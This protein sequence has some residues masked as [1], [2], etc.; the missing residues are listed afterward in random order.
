MAFDQLTLQDGPDAPSLAD[1][2]AAMCSEMELCLPGL[3]QR[4]FA[5]MHYRF[6]I[7]LFD[8]N[9]TLASEGRLQDGES[10]EVTVV[11]NDELR[12]LASQ[13]KHPD[14]LF[15]LYPSDETGRELQG[16]H[17]D[18]LAFDNFVE[19]LDLGFG[20]GL[21]SVQDMTPVQGKAVNRHKAGDTAAYLRAHRNMRL[22]SDHWPRNLLDL[23]GR[24][25]GGVGGGI[26]EAFRTC[27]ETS[28]L[29]LCIARTMVA[30]DL[31]SLD[32]DS[33]KYESGMSP[34]C[35]WTLC[36]QRG[37]STMWHADVLGGTWIRCLS[38]IKLWFI[39]IGLDK[40]ELEDF[41]RAGS[42][43]SPPPQ[44]VRCVVLYPGEILAMPPG[45]I[46]VHAPVTLTDC[47]MDGGMYW[48]VSRAESLLD[49]LEYII[50]HYETVTN[51]DPHQ[52][53][54]AVL[55]Q[56]LCVLQ[57][58]ADTRDDID[59]T[60][61]RTRVNEVQDLHLRT[62]PARTRKRPL[63]QSNKRRAQRA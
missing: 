29:S 16:K 58:L 24:V 38:G 9:F 39:C 33:H 13:G 26:P 23:G 10:R 44:K 43:W 48:T 50:E 63:K 27:P 6:V 37:S 12:L 51:E 55:D 28:L 47:L 22:S 5:A 4:S 19:T 30:N 41:A 36:A 15:K 52:D 2:F 14:G 54:V 32:K 40:E 49:S 53:L 17:A 7:D 25:L 18:D 60:T 62:M 61:I 56:L 31:Q 34:C 3:D 20:Q 46:W 35:Y 57:A 45:Q 11:T 21:V 59:M 42:A 8:N 1:K